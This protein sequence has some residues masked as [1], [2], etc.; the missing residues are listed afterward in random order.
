MYR[1]KT[2]QTDK[3]CEIDSIG[4]TQINLLNEVGLD[5]QL[6]GLGEVDLAMASGK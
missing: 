5:G 2:C 4:K 6:E 3:R 1:I